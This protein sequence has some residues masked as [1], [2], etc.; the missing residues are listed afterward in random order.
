M[1]NR[2]PLTIPEAYDCG[3]VNNE[4]NGHGMNRLVAATLVVCSGWDHDQDDGLWSITAEGKRLL[5]LLETD[6]P[7]SE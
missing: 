6:L 4:S 5:N 2:G 3:H 7:R 1:R